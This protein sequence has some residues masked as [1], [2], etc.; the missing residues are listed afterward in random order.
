MRRTCT[1]IIC[2]SC[3]AQCS[4]Q[5]HIVGYPPTHIKNGKCFECHWTAIANSHN[6][7]C[8][9]MTCND[10]KHKVKK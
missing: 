10:F 4:S 5:K 6:D 8:K 1:T 2:K 3:G 7:N 9:C